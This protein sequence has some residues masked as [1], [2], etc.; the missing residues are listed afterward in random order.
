VT[1]SRVWDA[2]QIEERLNGAVFASSSMQP[3]EYD[4]GFTERRKYSLHLRK[5]LASHPLE[6]GL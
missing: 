3:E 2:G 1:A 5:G 6:L 4:I